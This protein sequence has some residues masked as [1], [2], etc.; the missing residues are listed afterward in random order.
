MNKELLIRS[1]KRH[2]DTHI[3]SVVN[4]EG[5]F[6]AQSIRQEGDFETA[7]EYWRWHCMFNH[8]PNKYGDEVRDLELQIREIDKGLSI[9]DWGTYGT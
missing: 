6:V 8:D 3:R 9:P 2:I 5:A 7:Q 1:M 4:T